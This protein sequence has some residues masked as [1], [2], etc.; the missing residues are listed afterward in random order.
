MAKKQSRAEKIFAEYLKKQK[1]LVADPSSASRGG[2]SRTLVQLGAT[3]S[4]LLSATNFDAAVAEIEKHKPTIIICDYDLGSRCGL[5][6]LQD[7]RKAN[8]NDKNTLFVLV[9]GNTSQSA[10]AQAA[11]ED[12]DTFILKPYTVGILSQTIMKAALVKLYPSDYLKLVDRGKQEMFSGKVTEALKTFEEAMPLN[13]KPA[14]ACFYHGQAQFMQEV[15]EEAKDDYGKGLEYNKIHFKCL[16]G[17]YELLMKEKMFAEAYE[18]VKKISR[19]FPANPQRLTQVLRLAIMTKSYE[20]IERYYQ[21]FIDLE[22]RSEEMIKYICA[23]LVVCGKYYLM[24]KFSSRAMQLF[25]KAAT[26]A[27]GRT[28]ILREIIVSLLEFDMAKDAE[29]FLERF[30]ADS[31][32]GEDFLTMKY[33]VND[34]NIDPQIS[35]QTGRQ[36]IQKDIHDPEIYKVLIRRSI[37]TRLQDAAEE[38]KHTAIKKWPEQQKAMDKIWEDA[39]AA[40]EEA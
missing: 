32:E 9:T 31:R 10:V 39:Q 12:V 13:P 26:T 16:V 2:L 17:L 19:Y 15:L 28:K 36:L 27:S 40:L 20:D 8:P 4:N 30:P 18:I 14:L 7:M 23:A 6:L 3:T 37:E 38:L 25:T 11:E 22:S 29:K 5:D 24:T 1:V 21:I 35:V 34:K 33:L